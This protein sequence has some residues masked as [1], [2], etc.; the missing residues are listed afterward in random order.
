[1][2]DSTLPIEDVR[3]KTEQCRHRHGTCWPEGTRLKPVSLLVLATSLRYA[4]L[5]IHIEHVSVYGVLPLPKAND[6]KVDEIH[7]YEISLLNFS[8]RRTQVRFCFLIFIVYYNQQINNITTVRIT[9]MCNL[10][11]YMFRYF[12]IIIR[13]FTS[14][15]C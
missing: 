1:M 2:S 13:E 10:Y 11:F 12:C 4:D 9:A 3:Y 15:T 6:I 7:A 5:G 14:A 8:A